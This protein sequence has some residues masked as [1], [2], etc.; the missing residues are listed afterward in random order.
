MFTQKGGVRINPIYA[1]AHDAFAYFIRNS[2]TE[3]LTYETKGGILFKSKLKTGNDAAGVAIVSPYTSSRSNNPNQPVNFILF[4][5]CLLNRD[6]ESF[7]ITSR[8]N[9][10]SNVIE[11]NGTTAKDFV[12][13]IKTQLSIF[14][15]SLDQY[16]EPICP[17]IICAKI[18]RSYRKKKQFLDLFLRPDY[19]ANNPEQRRTVRPGIIEPGDAER[20]RKMRYIFEDVL[21]EDLCKRQ[22]LID[23]QNQNPVPTPPW[24][25]YGVLAMEFLQDFVTVSSLINNPIA[26]TPAADKEFYQKLTMYELWR[27]Y[28]IGPGYL[29]GDNHLENAMVNTNY[30]YIKGRKG[31]VLLIDF[32]ATFTRAEI[33]A[34]DRA[35]I[36]ISPQNLQPAN[37]TE[38]DEVIDTIFNC[39]TPRFADYDDGLRK[40]KN[41]N[42]HSYQWLRSISR[43]GILLSSDLHNI[44]R[45]RETLKREFLG[46]ILTANLRA[47]QAAAPQAVL[48]GT[49]FQLDDQNNSL[50][51][52]DDGVI[53][54]AAAVAVIG[55]TVIEKPKDVYSNKANKIKPFNIRFTP[56][57]PKEFNPIKNN[58]FQS[59]VLYKQFRKDKNKS[60]QLTFKPPVIT[61]TVYVTPANIPQRETNVF[62][63][64]DPDY[65][66]TTAFINSFKTDLIASNQLIIDFLTPRIDDEDQTYINTLLIENN[67]PEIQPPANPANP[68]DPIDHEGEGADDESLVPNPDYSNYTLDT[69]RLTRQP[70]PPLADVGSKRRNDD[71]E[72]NTQ[73]RRKIGGKK[74]KKNV[75]K[76]KKNLKNNLR[77]SKKRRRQ[78]K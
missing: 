29:H 62:D 6:E 26:V 35:T 58:R 34:D 16:L 78:Y 1:T 31:R 64:L 30:D 18:Y 75:R 39:T 77:K 66:F 60:L 46:H 37:N 76:S 48:P 32:G 10:G 54:A 61:D 15:D 68:D 21:N 24:F 20:E 69:N 7:T 57:K 14:N 27:L 72:G 41:K 28:N 5:M 44:H 51:D 38:M 43:R 70:D 49:F 73:S 71:E 23:N 53:A 19:N 40:F 52:A 36:V 33:L 4:K 8:S 3:V 9:P 13:E 65:I 45:G 55:G 67:N 17:S 47:G 11:L 50:F 25:Q 2:F 56:T 63:I 12:S 42:W 22:F 59:S 74:S